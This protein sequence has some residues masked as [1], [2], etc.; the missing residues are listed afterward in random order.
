MN[1]SGSYE[2]PKKIVQEFANNSTTRQ[3]A[4]Q[5]GRVEAGAIAPTTAWPPSVAEMSE[6]SREEYGANN[7]MGL[8]QCWTCKG[9]GHVSK[10]CPNGKGKGKFKDNFGK[11]E[12]DGNKGSNCGMYMGGGKADT[13]SSYGPVKGYGKGDGKSG[14]NGPRDGVHLQC[15]TFRTRLRK[16]WRKRWIQGTGYLGDMGR[17]ATGRTPREPPPKHAG[18]RELRN[19]FLTWADMNCNCKGGH[20]QVEGESLV[21]PGLQARGEDGER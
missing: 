3:E 15:R 9:Y 14:G 1:H 18:P 13:P 11:G 2:A 5:I 6:D 7:A 20:Q 19:R 8:Q 12:Y 17:A 16:M 10:D 21:P 4:M